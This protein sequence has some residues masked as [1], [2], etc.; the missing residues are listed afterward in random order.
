M[1]TPGHR[2]TAHGAEGVAA[3]PRIF[4]IAIFG[5]N[6]S[7]NIPA[8]PLGVCASNGK[9]IRA[10]DF[11]PPERNLSRTPMHLVIQE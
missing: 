10:R 3:P 5:Q 7:G 8:K 4:Q 2:R 6:K 1:L 9:N 11:S